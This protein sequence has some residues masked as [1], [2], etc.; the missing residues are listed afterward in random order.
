MARLVGTLRHLGMWDRCVFALTADHG[1]EFLDHGGRYHPPT[2]LMEE[3]I[4][5][6]L[7]LRVA[8]APKREVSQDPFSMLHLAPTLLDAASV[9]SPSSFRGLSHWE[10][11]R[12]GL[13]CDE[14]AISES[15]ADCTNPFHRQNRLGSRALSI[16]E[17]RF[18]LALNFADASDCL[19]DLESDPGELT[20]LPSNAEKAMRHRMLERAREHLRQSA[21]E[22]DKTMRLHSQL[23]DFRLNDLCLKDSAGSGSCRSSAAQLDHPLQL[24]FPKTKAS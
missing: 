17:R 14:A 1:E 23:R 4:H 12:N 16:R 20:A 6:P 7:L 15:V 18:K 2:R 8:G 5:V 10:N 11:L 13:G 22:R 3:L 24:Q 21:A 19:Y 9:P